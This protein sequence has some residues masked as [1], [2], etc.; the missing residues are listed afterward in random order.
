MNQCSKYEEKNNLEN[1]SII[2]SVVIPTF[3]IEKELEEC[4]KNI[5]EQTIPKNLYE[6]IIVDDCS[7]DLTFEIA[8]SYAQKKS[9]INCYQLS[10]NGGPGIARNKGIQ[11]AKGEFIFFLDGDDLL[12]KYALELL[13][14]IVIEYPVD[15]VTFNWAYL[16]NERLDKFIP[17]RRDLERFTDN[18]LNLIKLFL[19]MNFDG[20]VIYTMTSRKLIYENKIYFPSG[21]HEDIS[22]IFK[23]F[24]YSH[25]IHRENTVIYLKRKR[26]NS[27]VET[28]SNKHIQGYFDS[29]LI[30]K[31]FLIHKEGEFFIKTYI[32]DYIKGI[33]GLIAIS[34][35]KNFRINK[36]NIK[37]KFEI[38]QIIYDQMLKHFSHEIKN[39]SL[40]CESKYDQITD[41]FYKNFIIYRENIDIA[42]QIL[43]KKMI[44]YEFI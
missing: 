13:K 18:K 38:Y 3:N 43:E 20:S 40:P 6:V 8:K 14:N 11:K 1:T 4:L 39:Y 9:N 30:I 36:N 28:I 29:W 32:S 2:I 27:I 12:P 15:V 35:I 31:D 22:V 7:I 16:E 34:L 33:T 26:E 21:F 23:I 17:K 10:E 44:Q 24:Y 25:K 41:C 42:I 37:L 5:N 19:S